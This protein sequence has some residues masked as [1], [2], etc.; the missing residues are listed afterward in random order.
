[1]IYMQRSDGSQPESPQ[2][3]PRNHLKT[4][5]NRLAVGGG[6]RK[7]EDVSGFQSDGGL[8]RG[9]IASA[10]VRSVVVLGGCSPSECVSLSQSCCR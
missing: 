3:G 7:R 5:P 6:L 10:R 1:M 8:S 4:T 2:L 9:E